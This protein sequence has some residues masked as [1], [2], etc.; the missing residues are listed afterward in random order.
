MDNPSSIDAKK[1]EHR[2]TLKSYVLGLFLSVLLTL[3]S[4]FLVSKH[5]MTG[6]TLALTITVLGLIQLG[7]QLICFLYLNKEHK[8]RLNLLM[9]LFSALVVSILVGGSIWIM[10]NLSYRLMPKMT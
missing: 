3:T 6:M 2:S 8:P 10:Y 5:W 4:Y 7:V 9:F 1:T